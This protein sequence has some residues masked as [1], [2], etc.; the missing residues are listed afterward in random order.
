MTI[1]HKVV[2][3][4]T[5]SAA[6]ALS[7]FNEQ[8]TSRSQLFEKSPLGKHSPACVETC[9]IEGAGCG[10]YLT[11]PI[12]NEYLTLSDREVKRKAKQ[13]PWVHN[14][15]LRPGIT[16]GVFSATKTWSQPHIEA[17]F[18]DVRNKTVLE[19]GSWNGRWGFRTP[20]LPAGT[21]RLAVHV[22]R[23]QTRDFCVLCYVMLCY[24]WG[25]LAEERGAKHV[26][27]TDFVCWGRGHLCNERVKWNEDANYAYSGAPQCGMRE[28]FDLARAARKSK[29]VAI[30]IDPFD[31]SVANLGRC[32]DVVLYPGILY[33]VLNQARL[34]PPPPPPSF[35]AH[36]WWMSKRSACSATS[37]PVW[38]C[39]GDATDANLR[40]A[41]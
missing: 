40:R 22:S 16:S 34:A 41:L 37:H 33:H 23:L 18:P 17:A 5:A 21:T 31:L 9:A 1:L 13:L 19:L 14:I 32:F 25:F 12:R 38:M 7:N 27:M 15:E 10:Q 29:V 30:E 8:E 11:V 2:G 3:I 39:A 24:R 35:R 26:T 6:P 28:P 36:A 20:W 4:A